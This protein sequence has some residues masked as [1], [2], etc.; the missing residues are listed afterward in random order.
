MGSVF[1]S[2]CSSFGKA[3]PYETGIKEKTIAARKD[4]LQEVEN[5]I[6]K[7]P[8]GRLV[9]DDAFEQI[10]HYLLHIA[11]FYSNNQ[12]LLA[13]FM[14]GRTAYPSLLLQKMVWTIGS[15]F[16]YPGV[17]Y[18]RHS[19]TGLGV[20][21]ESYPDI[22]GEEIMTGNLSSKDYE[23]FD[24]SQ[25]KESFPAIYHFDPLLPKLEKRLGSPVTVEFGAE[26][27]P[28]KADISVPINAAITIIKWT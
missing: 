6:E 12:S 7:H 15:D 5:D 28:G 26:S 16:A 8:H 23:Y 4:L 13:T 27:I 25:I 17:L 18:S 2:L 9:L 24:R 1:I 11:L 10:Y 20:Q 21:I 14:Q 3:H 19:R 22:F